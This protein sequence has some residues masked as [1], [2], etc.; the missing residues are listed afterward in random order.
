MMVPAEA[1]RARAVLFARRS[2]GG[3]VSMSTAHLK[4]KGTCTLSNCTFNVVT[5]SLDVEFFGRMRPYESF[6]VS[7]FILV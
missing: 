3:T 6:K 2:G 1:K 5:R 7:D 4:R